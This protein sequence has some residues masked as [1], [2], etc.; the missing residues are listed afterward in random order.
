VTSAAPALFAL[1]V[2]DDP[3]VCGV[4]GRLLTKMGYTVQTLDNGEAALELVRSK[5]FDLCLVDKQLPG[6]GGIS[7]A[8]GIRSNTPDAVIIFIT[9]HATASSA[10][11]LVGIADEY[12]TKPFDLDT[13]RETVTTLVSRRRGQ[14]QSQ[15]SPA[16]ARQEG[17]KWVHIY[18]DDPGTRLLINAACEKLGVQVTTGPTL[19][20]EPPDVLVMA[21]AHAAFEVRKAIWGFQAKRRGF[22]VLLL[23]DPR[24]ASDSAAAV[25][26]KASWRISLPA[27]PEQ[28]FVV[29]SGAL[30]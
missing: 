23:T 15:P 1:I 5:T 29:L 26:L 17:Q 8:R 2:D 28:A 25:A 16:P 7:V 24:S 27:K 3:S 13:L 12:L 19:P 22:Q 14:R 30:R 11:E 20:A 10:D 4:F 21:A 9:G 6:V 18:L